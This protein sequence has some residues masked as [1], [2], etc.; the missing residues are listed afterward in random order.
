[1]V[2]LA[3]PAPAPAPAAA[4]V[5]MLP[6]GVDAHAND[7]RWGEAARHAGDA[8]AIDE[9]WGEAAR[10]AGDAC[11]AAARLRLHSTSARCSP[12]GDGPR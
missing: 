3:P 6:M 2:L 1:M 10:H 4:L 11:R 5:P 7:E 9:R 12:R 8:H